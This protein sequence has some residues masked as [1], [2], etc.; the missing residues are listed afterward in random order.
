M[1]NLKLS[2][3][4]R[5]IR[6]FELREKILSL[7]KKKPIHT[8][9]SLLILQ[10]YCIEKE[11]LTMIYD[12]SERARQLRKRPLLRCAGS[13]PCLHRQGL[14]LKTKW[15]ISPFFY[16]AYDV[17]AAR[18]APDVS[19]LTSDRMK[20]VTSFPRILFFSAVRRAVWMASSIA[21]PS[22][23]CASG[24]G[25]AIS[26]PFPSE[27]LKVSCIREA[28]SLGSL[29]RWGERNPLD[30]VKK[31]GKSGRSSSALSV[32]TQT[33]CV[34]KYSKVLPISKMDFT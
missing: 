31:A 27:K 28:A 32:A 26:S 15:S 21:R 23:W 24:I 12:G 10:R 22:A 19:R 18:E 7:N 13:K 25:T 4:I 11:G 20:G 1:R 29:T 6:F 14:L 9:V 8:S 30:R 2:Y 5:T 17:L 16:K 33:P 34:S 3:S